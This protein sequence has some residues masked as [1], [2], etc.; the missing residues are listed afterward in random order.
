MALAAAS[1]V[2]LLQAIDNLP[3]QDPNTLGRLLE[4][5]IIDLLHV[6][7]RAVGEDTTGGRG[8]DAVD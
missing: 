8:N 6:G 2:H 5:W 7:P 3:Q 4:T 1:P